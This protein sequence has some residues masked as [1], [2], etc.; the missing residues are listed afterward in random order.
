M[1]RVI[2]FRGKRVDTGEW[3][4]GNYVFQPENKD[5]YDTHWILTGRDNLFYGSGTCRETF[6]KYE[7]IPESVGEFTGLTDKNGK[8]IYE[9]DI[10]QMYK[11]D[12]NTHQHEKGKIWVSG[13]YKNDIRQVKFR[14][15]T[16]YTNGVYNIK[17]AF[18]HMARPGESFEVIGNIY[19]NKELLSH[20]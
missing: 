9:G 15:G 17:I 20:E 14:L 2:K 13:Y 4:Y 5:H 10:L 7:V 16:F 12:D 11:H 19:E 3:I 18:M 1:E 8:D 6:E